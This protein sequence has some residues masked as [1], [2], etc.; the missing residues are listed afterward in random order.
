MKKL[1][2]PL[3]FSYIFGVLEPTIN[4]AIVLYHSTS[5]KN[6]LDN[7]PI[8][9]KED[10][11][12]LDWS[13]DDCC[14][15]WFIKENTKNEYIRAHTGCDNLCDKEIEE[16]TW[17]DYLHIQIPTYPRSSNEVLEFLLFNKDKKWLIRVIPKNVNKLFNMPCSLHVDLY[18]V[19]SDKD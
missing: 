8:T 12:E 10:L 13:I 14:N 15:G 7:F 18:S 1:K 3:T 5:I 4:E 6:I 19:S 9:Y 17:E 16:S 11:S 2:E